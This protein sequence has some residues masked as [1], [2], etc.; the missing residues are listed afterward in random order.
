MTDARTPFPVPSSPATSPST[1]AALDF[2]HPYGYV[3]GE[4]GAGARGDSRQRP[5][6]TDAV[7]RRMIAGALGVRAPRKTG[8]QAAYEKAAR[9]K[10][11][12]RREREREEEKEKEGEKER[13]R[14]A[15]WED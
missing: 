11:A 2:E 4:P 3:D 14:R 7:A 5:A 8:E 15:V 1:T 6:K 13:A 12:K 9:E 10:E